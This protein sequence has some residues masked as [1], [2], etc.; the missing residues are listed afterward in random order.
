MRLHIFWEELEKE[1]VFRAN[2]KRRAGRNTRC[3][4]AEYRQQILARI[5]TR[6]QGV[7]E[8]TPKYF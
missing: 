6:V 1:G 8:K 3:H 5:S 4:V 2:T 7:V